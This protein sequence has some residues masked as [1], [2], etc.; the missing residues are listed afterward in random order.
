MRNNSCIAAVCYRSV[1]KNI[2]FISV[3]L[4]ILPQLLAAQE[5]NY[6]RIKRLEEQATRALE[7]Y[8]TELAIRYLNQL[9]AL[10]QNS[11]FAHAKLAE[12]YFVVRDIELA[13]THASRA[14]YFNQHDTEIQI[15]I[16]RIY[17]S[18]GDIAR[19]TQTLDRLIQTDP[20]STRLQLAQAE[21]SV[22]KYDYGEAVRLYQS[23]LSRDRN[24]IIALLGL[25]LLREE[26]NDF[27]ASEQL[28]SR[29]RDQ[30]PQRLAAYYLSAQH[31]QRRGQYA[32]AQRYIDVALQIAPSDEATQ[33]LASEIARARG[34]LGEAQTA[35]ESLIDND[36]R[37]AHYWYL[38]G[39]ILSEQAQYQAAIESYQRALLLQQDHE[40]SR[41][42]IE[43]LARQQLPEDNP[44]RVALAEYRFDRARALQERNL[45]DEATLQVRRGLQT[46]PFSIDGRLLFADIELLNGF[47]A[48]YV[49]EL[50][51]A[52]SFG[53]ESRRVSDQIETVTDLINNR[54]AAEWEVDQFTMTRE[55]IRIGVL[56]NRSISRVNTDAT[57]KTVGAYLTNVLR[58]SERIEAAGEP[59]ITNGPTLFQINENIRDYD[60]VIHCYLREARNSIQFIA[61]IF[62]PRSRTGIVTY[63]ATFVGS[64]RYSR[65]IRSIA[66]RIED[67]LPLLG[68]VIARQQD[69]V[70][71]NVGRVQG[72][73]AGDVFVIAEQGSLSA[74][75][76]ALA[77]RYP[78]ESE[79]GTLT[80]TVADDLVAEGQIMRSGLFD[81]VAI[82]NEVFTASRA[83][84]QRSAI[85]AVPSPLYDYLL[86][87]R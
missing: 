6:Q 83:L 76:S 18:E 64:R 71:V 57:L 54:P 86:Q 16:A 60:Y 11:F 62:S 24:D 48:K 44:R 29:A 67:A 84:P 73:E 85:P 81:T 65:A 74:A 5:S 27:I 10:D 52:Q 51:L 82:G 7:E 15:L 3:I 53:D 32:R 47:D 41:F 20:H 9:I 55:S 66:N 80:I 33:L 2:L 87:I 50:E 13:R 42:A 59:L 70:L 12:S 17:I 35:I 78:E 72:V 69:R 77:F 37:Q 58:F 63:R 21:L 49:R 36:N 22:A 4:L 26:Q 46:A 23:V 39:V 68:Q 1:V 43:D 34:A 45:L 40:L 14:L 31:Y 61:E 79:I 38:Y 75:D 25:A 19:A 56:M 30:A 28:I 8:E